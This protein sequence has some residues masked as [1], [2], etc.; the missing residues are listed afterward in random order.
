MG[1]WLTGIACFVAWWLIASGLLFLTWNKVISAVYKVKTVK[2]WQVLLLVATICCFV[3]PRA[4][5]NRCGSSHCHKQHCQ[6]E[7]GE[8]KGDCPYSRSSGDKAGGS[9]EHKD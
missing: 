9:A 2:Y 5:M 7:S 6:H 3:A 1:C 4:W 8:S